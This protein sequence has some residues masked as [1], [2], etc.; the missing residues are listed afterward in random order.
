MS[1]RVQPTRTRLAIFGAGGHAKVVADVILA[2]GAYHIVGIFDDATSHHGREIYG[3]PVLGS[4]EDL[5]R[6]YSEDAVDAAVVAIGNNS[7]RQAI[8]TALR[9]AGIPTPTLVHPSAVVSPTAELGDGTVVLPGCI[10]NAD[11]HIGMDAIVNTRASI[12]HDCRIGAAA[13]IA[14]GVALCGGVTVGE[15][16]L[17]GVGASAIPLSSIGDDTIVGGGACVVGELPA[18]VTATGVPARVCD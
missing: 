16:A 2:I 12:D 5:V 6:A 3:I 18:G 4:R 9:D 13:H 10:I 8:G 7:V 11:T 1:N 14:P 17:V 15:R